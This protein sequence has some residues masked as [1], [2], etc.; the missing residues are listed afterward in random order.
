M[1]GLPRKSDMDALSSG[2]FDR[3]IRALDVAYLNGPSAVLR[4]A[5]RRRLP[6][7]SGLI[8]THGPSSARPS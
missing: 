7:C 6:T 4:S 5:S 3:V 2:M 1:T 8:P